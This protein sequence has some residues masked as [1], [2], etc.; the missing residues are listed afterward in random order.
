LSTTQ[1]AIETLHERVAAAQRDLDAL[2][3]ARAAEVSPGEGLPPAVV[4]QLEEL[5]AERDRLQAALSALLTSRQWRWQRRARK[6]RQLLAPYGTRRARWFWTLAD[7]L[8]RRPRH[9]RGR[10]ITGPAEELAA[11]LARHPDRRGIIV[12]PA[13]TDW[14]WMKQRPHHLM[15]QFARAGYL[16]FY[17]PP[18]TRTD[19]VP[20]FARVGERL[21]LCGQIDWLYSLREPLVLLSKPQDERLARGF[22][23][24][25]IIYDYLDELSIHSPTGRV[26]RRLRQQHE[27]LLQTATVVCATATELYE[28]ARRTR[29]D[30]LL[31]P[32]AADFDH[33]HAAAAPAVPADLADLVRSGRPLIGYY[34]ALAP[35][36]DFELLRDVA[37]RRPDCEFVLI[38]PDYEGALARQDATRLPNVHVLGEKRYADLPAYLHRFSVAI[39]PFRLN[40]LTRATSPIKLFEYMA[41]GKPVVTTP[42]PECIRHELVLA[43]AD[44]ADFVYCL[45]R[46]RELGA[47]RE[48]R[49]RLLAAACENSWL[50]RFDT[51]HA[52]LVPGP[53]HALADV[54]ARRPAPHG[55][56]IFPRGIDWNVDLYQRPHHLAR[57]FARR[58]FRVIYVGGKRDGHYAGCR[59]VEPNLY[60][61]RG[62][63]DAL[64]AV[65]DPLLWCFCY[66]YHHVD[67]FAPG[68]RTLYDLI[69]EPAV[70]PGRQRLLHANHRRALREALV[71]TYVARA[72]ERLLKPRPDAVY[73]PNGVEVDRFAAPAASTP[74]DPALAPLREHTGL[75]AGYYGALA[76]WFDYDLLA[77]VARRRPEW[78]FLLIGPD[79]DGS[80]ASSGLSRCENVVRLGP[81]EY[82]DLPAYVRLFDVAMIPFRINDITRATSPLKLY[83]YFAAGK[84]VVTT[85]LPECQRHPEVH[86]AADAAGF[87]AALD[88]AS[89]EVCKPKARARLAELAR[90][91][92]WPQRVTTVIEHLQQ[93]GWPPPRAQEP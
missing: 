36:F 61:Y 68:T 79:Y 29:A 80:L 32:N 24:P 46:A 17:C 13:L 27:R 26:G 69:D 64:R 39:I 42:L 1:R 87:C 85:P 41:A 33:F 12:H 77:E 45:D 37:R 40:D 67:G 43:A 72:L 70:H 78:R 48:H 34:G 22:R 8:A 59:E 7:V 6:L 88:A 18:Q 23:D 47:D 5:A 91:N 20:G 76:K 3:A 49:H 66:N 90:Q 57:H 30:V 50:A 74:A 62:P 35:W 63:I 25:S 31:C 86:I 52:R 4:Q 15:S 51:L 65:P 53:V 9:L 92:S 81:R 82:E 2:Q 21:Y 75:V 58:G 84:P 93:A 73:L 11:I 16:A 19:Y 56:I 55:T 89:E 71:V 10:A 83:E 60:V 44:A 14:G 54:L 28:D 38:G